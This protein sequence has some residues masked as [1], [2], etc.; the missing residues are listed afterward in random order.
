MALVINGSDVK[1]CADL[2]A[3]LSSRLAEHKRPARWYLL[4]EIPRT[5]RGKINR[6]SVME[7]CAAI[8]PL[9]IRK[10]L[11]QAKSL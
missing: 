8:E 4:G 2:H 10:I 6:S 5:S 11:S 9:D 1:A 7:A 3:W